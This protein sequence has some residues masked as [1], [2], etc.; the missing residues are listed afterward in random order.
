M[1]MR[2][3]AAAEG[4][5]PDD[6]IWKTILMVPW[7]F[8]FSPCCACWHCYM[9]L[10]TLGFLQSSC[11]TPF[12]DVPSPVMP[13]RLT[14]SMWWCSTWWVIT[15]LCCNPTSCPRFKCICTT[16]ANCGKLVQLACASRKHCSNGEYQWMDLA[17]FYWYLSYT[18]MYYVNANTYIYIHIYIHA[19][20]LT[21]CISFLRS[22]WC[23]K[24]NHSTLAIKPL[25]GYHANQS[26]LW[27][28][29]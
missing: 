22:C 20:I 13:S 25:H 8:T 27:N 24:A 21:G 26:P 18:C 16:Q 15:E 1:E 2:L 6:L 10:E 11:C 23:W 9:G 19:C 28:A 14:S 3:L 5:A 4:L 12:P 7:H 29:V 17:R